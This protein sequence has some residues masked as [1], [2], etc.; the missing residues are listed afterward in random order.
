MDPNATLEE[1]RR[2]VRRGRFQDLSPIGSHR[3]VEL[4][5]GL[6][7]WLAGGGFLPRSWEEGIVRPATRPSL[8]QPWWQVRP[9]ELA[10]RYG[11]DVDRLQGDINPEDLADWQFDL[12]MAAL[13]VCE[14]RTARMRIP[15][16]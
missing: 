4:V 9:S 11:C 16:Q 5:E 1:I 15:E 12:V 8:N 14:E 13:V 6:D 3:L 10:W 7:R 2:L